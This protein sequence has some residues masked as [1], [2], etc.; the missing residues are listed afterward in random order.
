MW[1]I[2][3]REKFKSYTETGGGYFAGYGNKIED[4]YSP[5]WVEA[6]RYKTLG[7][8]LTRLHINL[9]TAVDTMEYFLKANT[10]SKQLKRDVLLNDLLEDNTPIEYIFTNGRID[11]VGSDG[12]FLGSAHV[13][14]MDF[15]TKTIA[16]NKAKNDKRIKKVN[17][18]IDGS[19][20]DY[21]IETK[22]GEDFWEG[23]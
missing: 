18:I 22:E 16:K 19:P 13:E 12:K 11:K 14:V 1:Y 2:V 8:A 15:V 20:M 21:I 6:Q 9:G 3:Y 7:P 5:N 17:E 4:K 23:F 10:S